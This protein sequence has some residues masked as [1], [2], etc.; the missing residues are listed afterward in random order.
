[1]FLRQALDQIHQFSAD[2]LNGL[3]DLLFSALINQCLKDTGVTTLRKRRLPM[4]L[5]VWSVVVMSLYRYL[6]MSKVVSQL[7]ILLPG[8]KPFVAPSAVIHAR[9]KLGHEP[10]EAVF[11][12]TQQ[13]WHEKTPHP[14]WYGLTLHAVDGVVWR[15]ADKD[16]AFMPWDFSIVGKAK[17]RRGTSNFLCVKG[18]NIRH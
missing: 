12:H 14:D 1:M 13:L 9:K 15:T 4:E 11:N 6:S 18:R 8:K 16:K 3:S 7:D 10:V 17:V 2:Q 5:M